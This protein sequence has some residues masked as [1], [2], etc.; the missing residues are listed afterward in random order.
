[1]GLIMFHCTHTFKFSRIRKNNITKRLDV[2][3]KTNRSHVDEA[4]TP[5]TT[6]TT[7]LPEKEMKPE[8]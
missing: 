6:T 3:E 4:Q 8:E 1:M 2:M 5:S 7:V